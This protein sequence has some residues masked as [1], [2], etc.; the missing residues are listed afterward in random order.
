MLVIMLGYLSCYCISY[1]ESEQGLK[2]TSD[3]KSLIIYTWVLFCQAS[4]YL[5][6]NSVYAY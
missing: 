2:I 4:Q 3:E 1:N 5:S 6:T